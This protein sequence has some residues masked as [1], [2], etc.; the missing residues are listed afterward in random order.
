MGHTLSMMAHTPTTAV[1]P[2]PSPVTADW[3]L[4]L[5]RWNGL[6]KP[7]SRTGASALLTM[8]KAVGCILLLSRRGR[9]G[10]RPVAAPE[11]AH[12]GLSMRCSR[13]PLFRGT[14]TT[15]FG[16]A[17]GA[18]PWQYPQARSVLRLLLVHPL[19]FQGACWLLR[20]CIMLCDPGR[21]S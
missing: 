18:I 16:I 6:E 7:T 19:L 15:V 12:L 21:G 4:C 17:A 11:Q 10:G 14:E 2:V 1:N 20:A 13:P 3:M 8:R 5:R 9:A